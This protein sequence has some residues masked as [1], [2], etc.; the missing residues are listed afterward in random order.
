M[1]RW[2]LR[3]LVRTAAALLLPFAVPAVITLL[4]WALPG[5]PASIICPPETCGGTAALAARWKLDGGPWLFYSSWIG[6]AL[7]GEFGASW[8]VIQGVPVAELLWDAVPWTVSL[9]LLGLVL[10]L[11][12]GL[13]GATGVL[14]EK[15]D[16][17]LYVV[18]L[19]PGVVL[20]LIAR[21]AADLGVGTNLDDSRVMFVRLGLGALVLGLADG[22]FSGAVTGIRG[23][24]LTENKQRYVHV[25]ILRG[26]RPLAN[27]LPNVAGALAGQ[28]RARLLHLLS[29]AVVVEVVMGI[30]GLGDLLW[31]GTLLQDFGVVV[32]AATAFACIS[33]VLLLV[34]ALIEVITAVHVRRSPRLPAAAG[35]AS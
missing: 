8:R 30:A 5:D 6:Q 20:A 9:I 3:P 29:G 23:L 21:A 19:V 24:F 28:M 12:G 2:W 32:A 18:G 11:L 17:L 15:L 22:A 25:A 16:G 4:I 35:A 13:L 34:Q 31:L 7:H 14:S 26:E 27:T 10:V 1:K 33:A